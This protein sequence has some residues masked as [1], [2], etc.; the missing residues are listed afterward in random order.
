MIVI[1]KK[2]REAAKAILP[3]CAAELQDIYTREGNG[4]KWLMIDLEDRGELY[5]DLF[6]LIDIRKN[7][8]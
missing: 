3:E 4:Q 8:S 7:S 2:E 1:G 5:D 6:R